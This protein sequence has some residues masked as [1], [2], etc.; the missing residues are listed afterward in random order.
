MYNWLLA[1]FRSRL[2]IGLLGLFG[3]FQASDSLAG[4][5]YI[6]NN[7]NL[8]CRPWLFFSDTVGATVYSEVQ[9]NVQLNLVTHRVLPLTSG[10]FPAVIP[11]KTWGETSDGGYTVS[12]QGGT[13]QLAYLSSSS[14]YIGPNN[15]VGQF[16]TP[17]K[18]GSFSTT[19]R[20]PTGV[21][22][23]W[24]TGFWSNTYTWDRAANGST[25]SFVDG[26][27][28]YNA[29][30]SVSVPL[31]FVGYFI[32]AT[33]GLTQSDLLMLPWG[34]WGDTSRYT[35][36][37]TY[38]VT[39][40]Q[41]GHS[42]NPSFPPD[43]PINPLTGQPY[44][45]GVY[46]WVWDSSTGHWVGHN[47]WTD[48]STPPTVSGG[49]SGQWVY[50]RNPNGNVFNPDSEGYE[51]YWDGTKWGTSTVPDPTS[52]TTDPWSGGSTVDSTA[53]NALLSAIQENTSSSKASL[54]GLSS[55]IP[56]F[57]FEVHADLTG[58]R[59][60]LN[61]WNNSWINR[62]VEF[63]QDLT[64][65]QD[66]L[67]GKLGMISV[68]TASIS[69]DTSAIRSAM[70]QV[71]SQLATGF[72]GVSGALSGIGSSLSSIQS[73]A[74][75]MTSQLG[76]IAQN[77]HD[78]V[79]KQ[80]MIWGTVNSGLSEANGHL[81]SLDS[82]VSDA[83]GGLQ[84]IEG[85]ILDGN[86][87]QRENLDLWASQIV[88]WNDSD[89]QSLAKLQHLCDVAD[90]LKSYNQSLAED[91]NHMRLFW[92]LEKIR[93]ISRDETQAA[94]E[95][96]IEERVDQQ[97]QQN[98]TQISKLQQL[99]DSVNNIPP[100]ET[101]QI[102]LSGV[103]SRLDSLITA[104]GNI[105]KIP[106]FTWLKNDMATVKLRL[107]EISNSLNTKANLDPLPELQLDK[108]QEDV[109]DK[110]QDKLQ[111]LW[112]KLTD[113]E[114]S[115]SGTFDYSHSGTPNPLWMDYHLQ[116]GVLDYNFH[117]DFND[118][119]WAPMM[120]Y[121]PLWFQLEVWSLWVVTLGLCYNSLLEI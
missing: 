31:N 45:D 6:V 12:V 105:G 111:S 120:D 103:E 69:S 60:D 53:A 110:L 16:S 64:S 1:S 95:S 117:L 89:N 100:S 8:G 84:R 75:G 96:S 77:T 86:T 107:S 57:R 19:T 52:G 83:V 48:V 26:N 24:L 59:S 22:Y 42:D 5:G 36:D 3:F 78:M 87:M 43:I 38:T 56:G 119:Q 32:P 34:W 68:H 23:I 73:S 65:I 76:S 71:N 67:A 27:V 121:K 85:K 44:S 13:H 46:T 21:W 90:T 106:D 11:S 47:K 109:R 25:I 72:G 104:V 88:H 94:T 33:L 118:D 108:T 14:G 39:A 97:V 114:D 112:D 115:V 93:W 10:G 74:S 101:P 15:F 102:D 91:S 63:M 116:W 40:V 58:I 82:R 79:Q 81:S 18:V 2:C 51:W 9:G 113:F 80:E 55:A 30:S 54:L 29:P 28:G 17:F 61:A 70:D 92:E 49:P 4:Q 99:I 41:T 62:D 50:G 35:V 37:G 98:D 7:N 20:T 66:I